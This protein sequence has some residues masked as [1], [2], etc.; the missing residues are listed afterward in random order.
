MFISIV[1]LG[2]AENIST[3]MQNTE[4]MYRLGTK[5]T[6]QSFSEPSS[7]LKNHFIQEIFS[8]I[9]A[10]LFALGSP[11]AILGVCASHGKSTIPSP[12]L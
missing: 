2:K 3:K 5:K 4:L 7:L 1:I 8:L 6:A 9:T 10:F 11:T 12:D